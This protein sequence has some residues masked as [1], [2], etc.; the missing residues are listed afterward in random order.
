LEVELE[1]DF[2]L[3]RMSFGK[4][5]VFVDDET[6]EGAGRLMKVVEQS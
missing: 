5:E 1:L 2:K 3:E 6:N 4:F